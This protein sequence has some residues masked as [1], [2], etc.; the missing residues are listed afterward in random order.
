MECFHIAL[1][2]FFAIAT[3]TQ[4]VLMFMYPQ[5]WGILNKVMNG[6]FDMAIMFFLYIGFYAIC[7]YSIMTNNFALYWANIIVNLGIS[8]WNA[9]RIAKRVDLDTL[10]DEH[11]II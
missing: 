3:T 8:F 9:K 5:A 11:S 6:T 10:I 7:V 1:T 2:A 4:V